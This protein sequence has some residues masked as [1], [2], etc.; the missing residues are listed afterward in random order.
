MQTSSESESLGVVNRDRV[1]ARESTVYADDDIETV[2]E[3]IRPLVQRR[4]EQVESR[5][6]QQQVDTSAEGVVVFATNIDS[7]RVVERV[8]S[9]LPP[10]VE[11]V[12]APILETTTV[13][14]PPP[15]VIPCEPSSS[16]RPAPRMDPAHDA[17]GSFSF[18]S[19][20]TQLILLAEASF[21]SESAAASQSIQAMLYL[22]A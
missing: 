15:T 13:P 18:E 11:V 2:S 17:E 5:S 14:P 6:T 7:T 19:M 22:L 10:P 16:T 20:M 4:E 8:V 3:N 1:M 12:S 21:P 9:R